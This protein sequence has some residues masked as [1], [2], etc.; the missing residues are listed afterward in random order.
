MQITSLPFKPDNIEISDKLSDFYHFLEH[1]VNPQADEIDHNT[2][3]L[4]SVFNKMA[5]LKVFGVDVPEQLGGF[6]LDIA[7]R[8]YFM[9]NIIRVS[10]ALDLLQ[11]QHQAALKALATT[12]NLALQQQYLA[13]GMTGEMTYGIAYAHLRSGLNNP[14]VRGKLTNNGY[15]VSGTLRFV[16]GFTIFQHLQIGFVNDAGEEIIAMAPFQQV[17]HHFIISDPM[18]LLAGKSTQTV[19]IAVHD[20]DISHDA[21]ISIKPKGRFYNSSL[22]RF[23]HES[24]HAGTALALLD[25]VAT[26]PRINEE[27][28]HDFYC[29]LLTAVANYEAR[30]ITRNPK[31]RVAPVRARGVY[32]VNQCLLFAAQVFRGV[33]VSRKHPL[34]RLQNEALLCASIGADDHLMCDLITL[35]KNEINQD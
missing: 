35:M 31:E 20:L 6:S 1:E 3:K 11:I 25:L 4:V 28:I 16:T 22:T 34:F 15:K 12:S 33:G 21:I 17:N 29:H 2:A 8:H 27:F 9:R 13:K 5:S 7:Q 26:S 14:P 24:I 30:V 19:S 23:N 10:A 18:D 32:L